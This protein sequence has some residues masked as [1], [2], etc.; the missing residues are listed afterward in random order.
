VRWRYVGAV[1]LAVVGWG[2]RLGG[3]AA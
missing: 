2:V 3:L 1:S